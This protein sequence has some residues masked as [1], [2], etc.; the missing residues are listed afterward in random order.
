M[1]WWFETF[2]QILKKVQFRCWRL[3]AACFKDQLHVQSGLY[4]EIIIK[5][6]RFF[7]WLICRFWFQLVSF[8]RAES[9]KCSYS[10][11]GACEMLILSIMAVTVGVIFRHINWLHFY[12]ETLVC[13]CQQILKWFHLIHWWLR[14]SLIILGWDLTKDERFQVCSSWSP[15]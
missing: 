10:C 7:I 1:N 15:A 12:T 4:T 8:F 14:T 9:L 11:L 13:F 3:T 6:C 2:N 5:D